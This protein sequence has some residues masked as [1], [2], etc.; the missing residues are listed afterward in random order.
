MLNIFQLLR[1]K[2]YLYSG[3]AK[4]MRKRSNLL[5]TLHALNN[6]M[7]LNDDLLWDIEHYELGYEY[8]CKTDVQFGK[9]NW[10]II[11][12]LSL[13]E[14]NEFLV[15]MD[16]IVLTGDKILLYELKAYTKRVNDCRD[17]TI[18]YK[19]GGRRYTHPLNQLSKAYGIL[20]SLL[21]KLGIPLEIESYVLLTHPK[22]YIYNLPAWTDKVLIQSEIED[23]IEE[24]MRKRQPPTR[25]TQ[26]YWE[27]LKALHF[28]TSE[29]NSK[30]PKYSYEKLGKLVKCPNC[31]GVIREIPK[32]YRKMNCPCCSNK[33]SVVDIAK[34]AYEDYILLFDEKPSA[35]KL[36]N[37]CGGIFSRNRFQKMLYS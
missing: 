31:F 22:S 35:A 19:E 30:V 6:R 20:E 7:V 29:Y 4:N 10:F 34:L 23:H 9:G 1:K 18:E 11:K 12:G 32:G 37:W 5:R 14:R 24:Q 27:K 33:I 13:T 26:I 25:E 3:G 36:Y 2:A 15:Q 28:D 8:E 17:G 16:L 21:I